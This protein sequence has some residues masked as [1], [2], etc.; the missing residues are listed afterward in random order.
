ML[1]NAITHVAESKRINLI[2]KLFRSFHEESIHGE[3]FSKM[4]TLPLKAYLR[5]AISKI[6]VKDL[7]FQ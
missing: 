6:S 1:I 7:I 4:T 5:K 3:V 2:S